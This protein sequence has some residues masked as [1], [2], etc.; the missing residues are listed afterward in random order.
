MFYLPGFPHPFSFFP[1]HPFCFA[2]LS[3]AGLGF[4]GLLVDEV[5]T[6][7]EV[8]E[9]SDE[10]ERIGQHDHVHGV[11]EVAVGKQVVGGVD[12][13]YEK[14]E[15]ERRRERTGSG[16]LSGKFKCG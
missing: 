14:L 9:E 6:V 2:S 16:R 7:V 5:A 1:S 4:L 10:A 3:S 15:L 13:H 11:R 8:A 12:G